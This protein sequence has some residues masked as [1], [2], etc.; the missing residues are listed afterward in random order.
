ME[1]LWTYLKLIVITLIFALLLNVGNSGSGPCN[2]PYDLDGRVEGNQEPQPLNSVA[3]FSRAFNGARSIAGNQGYAVTAHEAFQV[4]YNSP[5]DFAKEHKW[6]PRTYGHLLTHDIGPNR[7]SLLGQL[8][9]SS[10]YELVDS[11]RLDQFRILD[12]RQVGAGGYRG[13]IKATGS[14]SNNEPVL[15]VTQVAG[16]NGTVIVGGNEDDAITWSGR[17]SLTQGPDYPVNLNVSNDWIA[18][19]GGN[20]TLK[21]FGG[22]DSLLGGDDNDRLLGDS[23]DDLLVGGSGDDLLFGGSGQDTFV[24]GDPGFNV[25]EDFSLRSTTDLIALTEGLTYLELSFSDVSSYQFRGGTVN[26][27]GTLISSGSDSLGLVRNISSSDLESHL[28]VP[29]DDIDSV[30]VV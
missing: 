19:D 6:V 23:G 12:N 3:K 29:Y 1:L 4:H 8:F 20:D 26:N 15:L 2:G 10:T 13:I 25:I 30:V 14:S 7:P 24:I 21:G 27:R 16:I 17:V 11:L 18:G 5:L 28:F 9:G 22:N